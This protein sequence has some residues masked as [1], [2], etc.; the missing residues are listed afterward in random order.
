MPIKPSKRITSLSFYAFAE[1]EQRA[2]EL[3]DKGINI[4]DF[5]V[6]DPTTPT[7]QFIRESLKEAVDNRKSAGYPSYVGAPEYR[8]AVAGW[9]NRRYDL[10]LDPATEICSTIGAAE[11]IFNLPEA[12][13]DPGD[14][15]LVPN[16]GYPRYQRGALFAEGGVHYLN[17]TADN[18]FFP[19]LDSI[20]EE[21]LK[22]AKLL[23][24]N[25]PNNPTGVCAT[26]KFYEQVV[27]F[28]RENDILIASDEAYSEIYFT[29]QPPTT[30]LQFS[31]EGVIVINSL[32]KRSAMTTYR[33][34]WAAGDP[35]A[36][37]I[38]KKLKTNVDSGTA[39]FIQDAAITALSD[40]DH[41]AAM[42]DEYRI[43][44]DIMAESLAAMG[45][46]N[47]S[48]EAAMYIWQKTPA[49]M[50]SLELATAL[51]DEDIAVMTTPGAWIS[52]EID[53]VNPGE[54]YIRLALV[55]SID[56][57]REAAKRLKQLKF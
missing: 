16:P 32:S 51:L 13:I 8:A 21:I 14:I 6:G 20:P 26:H 24:I 44:R 9:M 31:R 33:I 53:G 23:W 11:T 4:I 34:G 47:C 38:F 36:I 15:V 5:G 48:P 2:Q 56:D 57:C 50:T 30:L 25:Y 49:G 10:D 28:G 19:D 18:G 54:G 1:V 7:P 12:F 43:K 46:P 29:D 42:R 27:R 45:L 22:K 3:M 55:P 35:K 39:T 17:L 41:V 52:D 37:E 40:E